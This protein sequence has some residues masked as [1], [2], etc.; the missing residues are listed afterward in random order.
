MALN[1]G[2]LR[3]KFPNV[4]D[5][6]PLAPALVVLLSLLGLDAG[7]SPDSRNYLAAAESLRELGT[8]GDG[9]LLWPP[10]YPV[11][12]AGHGPFEPV[13]FAALIG[14][15]GAVAT[16][17]GLWA[18]CK[19]VR[20]SQV[21]QC[22][23]L[24]MLVS[25]TR[26]G[27]LFASV[28]SETLYIPLVVW[29]IHG[30]ARYLRSEGGI[31]FP[32]LLVACAL[33]TRHVGIVLVIAVALASAYRGRRGAV[34]AAA[35]ACVPWSLWL[36]RTYLLCGSPM[37]PRSG[38]PT[39]DLLHQLSLFG[40]TWGH[41][42]FPHVYWG[43]AMAGAVVLAAFM[44][45]IFLVRRSP[46]LLPAAL[47]LAG[48]SAFTVWTASRTFLD[49]DSRTLFPTVP[50]ALLISAWGAET[51]WREFRGY[52]AV[53]FKTALVVF[54]FLW[55]SAPNAIVNELVAAKHRRTSLSAFEVAST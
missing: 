28:W 23:V 38:A 37:G 5:V 10:L 16:V 52:A 55:F 34:I 2:W 14:D 1:P 7:Q 48:H 3:H 24:L 21:T 44:A 6:W 30:W 39:G 12:L 11:V 20:L 40:S 49:T 25:I 43:E 54:L 8:P 41:W 45:S 33:L 17:L 19:T 46:A 31:Y 26:F 50:F 4:G 22:V 51:C 36:L 9:Y 32:A 53:G 15:V 29:A 42:L 13:T 47:F 35:I 18:L 27:S